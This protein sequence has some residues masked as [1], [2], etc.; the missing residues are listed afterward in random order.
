[1]PVLTYLT[2]YLT[3]VLPNGQLFPA[4]NSIVVRD[5]VERF[6][7][8][9]FYV[10]LAEQVNRT[11]F[12]FLLCILHDEKPTAPLESLFT[13]AVIAQALS[14]WNGLPTSE[15]DLWYWRASTTGLFN[16]LATFPVPAAVQKQVSSELQTLLHFLDVGNLIEA[17]E[18]NWREY[19][20]QREARLV[21]AEEERKRLATIAK[22]YTSAL[23]EEEE[24]A[25]IHTFVSKAKK[26]QLVQ[27]RRYKSAKLC[28]R[29][30]TLCANCSAQGGPVC[31][32]P[33]KCIFRNYGAQ[34]PPPCRLCT[35]KK[36]LCLNLS[37][38]WI[39]TF[40]RETPIPETANRS[41]DS[42]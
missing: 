17:S 33:A 14:D 9:E 8:P 40:L 41:D 15:R 23:D 42:E 26:Q 39:S 24:E 12:F 34:V 4:P 13:P 6:A 25:I 16:L 28:Q 22:A 35:V 29:F 37:K 38:C 30:L 2:P 5:L 27:M 32:N 3:A 1:M 18:E 7:R 19:Q 11:R 10:P 36:S 31:L 20:Q 21:I